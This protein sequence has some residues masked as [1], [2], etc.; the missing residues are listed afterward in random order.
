MLILSQIL[1]SLICNRCQF[2]F[3]PINAKGALRSCSSCWVL[4]GVWKGGLPSNV[5]VREH[6]PFNDP[7]HFRRLC[8]PRCKT[9][10]RSWRRPHWTVPTC[11]RSGSYCTRPW[12][13]MSLRDAMDDWHSG[14]RLRLERHRWGW[15][16]HHAVHCCPPRTFGK[17]GSRLLH[18]WHW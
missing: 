11:G 7:S 1:M 9:G 6:E 4:L 8:E 18:Q 17:G 10:S 15:L 3:S 14:I 5:G 16:V 2:N 13:F 12:R